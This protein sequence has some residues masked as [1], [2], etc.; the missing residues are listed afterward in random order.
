MA[1][2]LNP[3]AQQTPSFYSTQ[4]QW[5]EFLALAPNYCLLQT[6]LVKAVPKTAKNILDLGSATGDTVFRIAA[7][8]TKAKI[9]ASDKRAEVLAAAKTISVRK[10]AKNVTF[11]VLDFER[12]GEFLKA[13]K[14]AGI[15][16]DVV[17][18]L[19][20]FHH[21]PDPLSS[22]KKFAKALFSNLPNGAKV[23]IADVCA[24]IPFGKNGY[25][26]A[27]RK[28][29]LERWNYVFHGVQ[30]SLLKR[31]NDSGVMGADAKVIAHNAAQKAADLEADAGRL[32]A[33][34][35]HEYPATKQELRKIFEL[36]GFKIQKFLETNAF[37]EVVL[38][39]VK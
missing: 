21:L 27:A 7:K 6:E 22:K 32:V 10:N 15:E 31:L 13:Q 37:G 3:P 4:E 19:Y 1:Q 23:I 26:E 24:R 35:K 36:A 2:A 12:A 8:C 16:F 9:I 17:T 29:W 18:S 34:R 30:K 5:A 14:R 28:Q 39:A 20:S 33:L 38:V 25:A 11:Q